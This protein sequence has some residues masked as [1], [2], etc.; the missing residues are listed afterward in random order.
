MKKL[1]LLIAVI[2]LAFAVNAFAKSVPG[3]GAAVL[4]E[5]N[6]F[7]EIE[8][9]AKKS[10]L[11]N[12]LV[13]YFKSVR[14]DSPELKLP[15]IN[16]E[17]L[18][19]IKSFK[20]TKRYMKGHTVVY[21]ILAD[22]DDVSLSNISFY[23]NKATNSV[24]FYI[25]GLPGDIAQ[26]GLVEKEVTGILNKNSFTTAD[27][28]NFQ[29]DIYYKKNKTDIYK[30]F[31]QTGS[32]FLF[33]FDVKSKFEKTDEF[34]ICDIDLITHIY[35]R[36]AEYKPILASTKSIKEVKS[37]CVEDALSNAMNKTIS[38]VRKELVKL[39]QNNME[40]QTYKI[41]AKGFGKFIRVKD[42]IDKLQNKKVIKKH[43]ISSY[44]M[45]EVTF[46]VDSLF[47]KPSLIN[48]IIDMTG[49]FNYQI[50]PSDKEEIILDFTFK[51]ELNQ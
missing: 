28:E 49:E 14:K 32:Q 37:L 21:Q 18:K 2:I 15:A 7:Y 46:E 47:D 5:K 23:I 10:A 45:N 1:S 20:I 6:S 11:V 29:E 33:A 38:Y 16:D 17:Y 43:R 31:Q 42:F 39:P 22:I 51:P 3:Y 12:A 40:I 27:N 35:S 34:V 4:N 9:M 48:K 8:E 25:E 24:V 44:A 26:T 19:F 41:Q 30:I 50:V 36:D 13:R